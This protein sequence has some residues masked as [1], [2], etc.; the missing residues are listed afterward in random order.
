MVYQAVCNKHQWE[1]CF[2]Q[3]LHLFDLSPLG[4]ATGGGGGG[5]GE[6][7]GGGCGGEV[8][9]GGVGGGGGCWGDGGR[10]WSLLLQ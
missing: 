5:E 6:E 4:P 10:C 1:N 9:G 2:I 7:D 3:N 8:G